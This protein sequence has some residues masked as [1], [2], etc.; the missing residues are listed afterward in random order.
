DYGI[1]PD[2]NEYGSPM[3]LFEMMAMEVA[4][5]SPDFEPIAEV[6]SDNENGWLFTRKDKAE[7][8]EITLKLAGDLKNIKRVGDGARKYI[9]NQRQWKHNAE[10]VLELL[11]VSQ[12]HP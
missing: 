2:S 12:K 3:K 8:V 9:H 1:L 6:V 4:L 5:V 10:L 11:S 7:A